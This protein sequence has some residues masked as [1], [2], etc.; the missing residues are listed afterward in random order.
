MIRFFEL[1]TRGLLLAA[2]AA[3]GMNASPCSAEASRNVPSELT[4][5]APAT[6]RPVKFEVVS[7]V[8]SSDSFIYA[9]LP[10]TDPLAPPPPL[11]I[12]DYSWTIFDPTFY[13]LMDLYESS[14]PTPPPFERPD[15]N[16]SLWQWLLE[17]N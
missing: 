8:P 7:P 9:G 17:N 12:I 2:L 5:A 14:N 1:S 4:V 11:K 15:D 16:S 10:S 3:F 13:L 6:P